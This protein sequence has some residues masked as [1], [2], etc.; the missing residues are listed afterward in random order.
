MVKKILLSLIAFVGGGILLSSAQNKQISGTVAN[1]EGKPIAGATI[2]IE[3]T[4]TGTTTTADGRFSISAPANGTLKISFIGYEPQSIAIAGKTHIDI[5][6]NED[7]TSID[8]VVV[9]GYGSGRKVGTI[10]G[11]V[12]QVKGEKL[13]GR[14]TN[15]VM[16]AMQGQVPG[17]QI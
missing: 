11:S 4:S 6:L 7:M 5:R 12:D 13:E 16:D 8:N 10:I 2:L 9:I 3:G 14:P 17:L 15:N 1:A